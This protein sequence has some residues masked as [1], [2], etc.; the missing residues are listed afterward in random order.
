MTSPGWLSRYRKVKISFF[1]P[2]RPIAKQSFRVGRYGGYQPKRVT[3]FKKLARIIAQKAASEQGWG[4]A[5]GPL[6]LDLVFRFRCPKSAKKAEKAIERWNIRRP[7]LDNVEK[8]ITDGLCDLMGDDSQVC[9][10]T[11]RK[12]IAPFGE[13]EGIQVTLQ[14]LGDFDEGNKELVG[15]NARPDDPTGS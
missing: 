13:E 7:D 2:G 9:S 3:D 14:T 8:S 12:T 4:T 1:V 5:D 11:S 6:H 15:E 10:K